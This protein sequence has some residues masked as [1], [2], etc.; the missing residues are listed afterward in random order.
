MNEFLFPFL[1]AMSVQR[2][3]KVKQRASYICMN[4]RNFSFLSCRCNLETEKST[5]DR[6]FEKD[7]QKTPINREFKKNQ[8]QIAVNRRFLQKNRD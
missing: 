1:S 6:D 3:G 7:R 2:E 4:E 8:S 5:I